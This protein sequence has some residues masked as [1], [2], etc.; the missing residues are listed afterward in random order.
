MPTVV[1]GGFTLLIVV[2]L[3]FAASTSGATFGIYNDAWDG[4]SNLRSVTEGTGA[5]PQVAHETTAYSQV[6][7]NDTV[8]IILS[9]DET[10][11]TADRVRLQRFIRRGGTLLV[12]GDYRTQTN[13]L[14]SMLGTDARLDG[15]PIR[16][17]RRHYR[18]PAMPIADN[19]SNQ[20]LVSNVSAL[21]LNHGTVVSPRGATVLVDTSEYGYL[22]VNQNQKLDDDE[23]ISSMPVATV[24]Q[25]G[26]G[27]VFVV[28]DPSVLINTMLDRP[29]NRAF[30]RAVIGNHGTVVLDYSHTSQIPPLKLAVLIIRESA[31]WQLLVGCGCLSLILL[32]TQRPSGVTQ[33]WNALMARCSDQPPDRVDGQ[34][35]SMSE[36]AMVS[37]LQEQHP[38]WD[39]VRIQRIVTAYREERSK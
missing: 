14:L 22:D 25:I 35:S 27:R 5:N 23:T 4:T 20:S 33:R 7:P 8:G 6:N 21:T 16:D 26:A 13:H 2:S 30:V 10:Y 28:S 19:V 9:P 32:W 12:A 38:N 29:G 3:L 24:E 11:S 17:E 18:S 39:A 15:R 1:L 34:F 31:L 37:Y 36:S